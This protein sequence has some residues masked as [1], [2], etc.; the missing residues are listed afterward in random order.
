VTS[1]V[2]GWVMVLMME[3]VSSSGTLVNIYQTTWHNIPEDSHLS[4]SFLHQVIINKD[5]HILV[6]LD[7]K[8]LKL[9][10]VHHPIPTTL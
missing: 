10:Q 4:F 1:D 5:T 7:I 3:A 2:D 9:F 8:F 6:I